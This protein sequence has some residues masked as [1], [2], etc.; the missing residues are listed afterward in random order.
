MSVFIVWMLAMILISIVG[1]MTEI[2]VREIK[3]AKFRIHIE[4][5]KYI[6]WS[7][8]T[9]KK[10]RCKWIL[11]LFNNKTGLDVKI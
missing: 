2:V 7:K 4:G 9:Q 11:L 5:D 1:W 3:S 10:N 6:P 8:E